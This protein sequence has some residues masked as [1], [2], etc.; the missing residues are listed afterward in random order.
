MGPNAT[1]IAQIILIAF[2]LYIIL[3]ATD[4]TSS[5][6]ATVS[7]SAVGANVPAGSV[8]YTGQLRTLAPRLAGGAAGAAG[9][10]KKALLFGLN[11]A[12]TPNA[13]L[14]CIQDVRNIRSHLITKGFTVE[15]C[16]DDL[17]ASQRPTRAIMIQKLTA[18]FKGLRST[19]TAFVWYSGHGALARG[20]NVWV[21]WDFRSA[22]FLTES[23]LRSLLNAVPSGVRIIVG[24][25]SCYS[26]SFFDLKYDMEPVASRLL[27]ETSP[28]AAVRAAASEARQEQRDVPVPETA[29]QERLVPMSD[30]EPV[31]P[32]IVA[33]AMQVRY[34]LYDSR[35][36][37]ALPCDAVLISGCRDNQTAADAYQEGQ[38]QGA[39]TWAFLK[40]ARAPG[41]TLGAL[42]DLM[43]TTLLTSRPRYS[44][45]PQLS[46]GTPLSPVTPISA[47]GL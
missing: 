3:R 9:G 35:T 41:V 33:R 38:F 2:L 7:S 11:Y 4:D 1:T 21:P 43:R 34:S 47:F 28:V 26:G 6:K 13:L 19:D 24:S 32:Q 20:E 17:R 8:T 27:G 10:T 46:F 22:G 31:A 37:R 44:Q 14:G 23:T 15:M 16:T 30:V 45:V 5:S 18:F 40:A 36:F 39:M 29:G 12:N 25:D 42:Q